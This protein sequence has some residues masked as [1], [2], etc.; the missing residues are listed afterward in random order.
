MD[1]GLNLH[2]LENFVNTVTDLTSVKRFHGHTIINPQSVADHSAR[3]A[4]LAY[5]LAREYYG[6]DQDA[7]RVATF[8]LFHDFSEGV[9]KNDVNSAIRATL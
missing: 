9:L 2:E 5:G 7:Y 8:A 3:V 6:N 1:D 4:M